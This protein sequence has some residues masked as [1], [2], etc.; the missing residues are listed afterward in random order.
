MSSSTVPRW[1][2]FLT[3]FLT[4]ISG[5]PQNKEQFLTLRGVPGNGSGNTS[6]NTPNVPPQGNFAGTVP[7]FLK[8]HISLK[9]IKTQYRNTEITHICARKDFQFLRT[10]R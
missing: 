9:S 6:G 1:F 3:M 7:M 8:K 5:T 2:L 4:E 10:R